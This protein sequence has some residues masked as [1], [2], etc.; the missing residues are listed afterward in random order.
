LQPLLHCASMQH[1]SPIH[2]HRRE[3]M[4]SASAKIFNA[5][6]PTMSLIPKKFTTLLALMLLL[7]SHFTTT[8]ALVQGS[9]SRKLGITLGDLFVEVVAASASTRS[10]FPLRIPRL[11]MRDTLEELRANR[12][13]R[14]SQMAM[15]LTDFVMA[16]QPTNDLIFI[17]QQTNAIPSTAAAKCTK[18]R[19]NLPNDELADIIKRDCRERQFLF[20]ADMTRAIYDDA[21]TFKDGSDIDGSYPL[22][23]WVRGCKLLFDARRSQ[24]KILEHTLS[25]TDQKVWFRFTETLTFKTMLQPRVYLTGTVVMKRDPESG[26]IVTYEEKWDQDMNEIF[27]RTQFSL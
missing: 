10:P 17:S 22:D 21:A 18:K 27:R 7:L 3:Q 19:Y 25:V 9:D 20:T 12:R 24:C 11:P 2:C 6:L 13:K 1:F 8:Y 14:V 23:A 15:G 26:L 5:F 16:L 4:S